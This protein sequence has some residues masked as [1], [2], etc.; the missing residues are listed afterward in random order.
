LNSETVTVKLKNTIENFLENRQLKQYL[1]P[2]KAI[3]GWE[4][5]RRKEGLGYIQPGQHPGRASLAANVPLLLPL[6]LQVADDNEAITITTSEA[7][8][9]YSLGE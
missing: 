8:D 9:T 4:L 5:K 7:N 6:S 2:V 1:N 3:W